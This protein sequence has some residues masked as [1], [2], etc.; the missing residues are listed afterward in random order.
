[1]LNY[2]IIQNEDVTLRDV[3]GDAPLFDFEKYK[4]M[5]LEALKQGD[6]N[7][8]LSWFSKGLMM[9]KQSNNQPEVDQFT[10]LILTFL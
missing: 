2:G 1:M 4:V 5:G 10:K 6:E 9:A 8:G 7:E 3:T